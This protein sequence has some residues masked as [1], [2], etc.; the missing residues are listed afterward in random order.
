[1]EVLK[2]PIVK[3]LTSMA[4]HSFSYQYGEEVDVIDVVAKAWVD[5]GI[6]ESVEE[7]PKKKSSLKKG[8]K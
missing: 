5:A 7:A 3:M 8:D 4:G 6:A 2:L 1:M